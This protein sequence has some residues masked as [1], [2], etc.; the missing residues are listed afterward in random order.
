M[1]ADTKTISIHASPNKV[2]RFLADPE[3]LPRWAVDFAKSVRSENGRWYV[4]TGAGEIGI[5]IVS[6]QATGVIDF[7]MSAAPGVEALAASRVVPRGCESE[8][9]FTQ[10]QPPGMTDETFQKNVMALEHELTVLKVSCRGGVSAVTPTRLSLPDEPRLGELVQAARAGDHDAL[11]ELVG[12][13]VDDVYRL[14]LRITANRADAEDASQ[15]I[16]IKV[17]TRLDSFRGE[18]SVRTWTYR[19]AVRHLL[20]RNK[21]RVEALSLD[22]ER[23]GADLLHGL[24]PAALPE[25]PLVT[26]EVKLGCTLAML[27]C[28]DRDH[29]VAY[30]LGE[31][32]D[33]PGETAA[34]IAG[35]TEEAHRQRLSRARRQ[36]EA[37]TESYCG[38][39]NANAPCGC[40]RRVARAIEL[41]RVRRENLAL[42]THPRRELAARVREMEELHATAALMRSH[43][44]YAAPER[45]VER[46]REVLTTRGGILQ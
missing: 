39:V 45:L 18:A 23:F 38:L 7:W 26:E 42:A 2:V 5:R 13:L 43:P 19:I 41:G 15:E 27:T 16:M 44:D 8:Y 3:N 11:G 33:L 29:R 36:L 12:V 35:V 21:S 31:V 4:Q 14:A 10:F 22:F 24:Q 34:S 25:E 20:D 32:F 30:V 6:D 9:T 46:I 28:L 40:D 1:R 17:I 37:F